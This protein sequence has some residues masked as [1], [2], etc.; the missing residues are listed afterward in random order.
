[1]KMMNRETHIFEMK[2]CNDM[3]CVKS[4]MQYLNKLIS[5]IPYYKLLCLKKSAVHN[6]AICRFFC[7]KF[8]SACNSKGI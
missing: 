8:F 1:M 6:Y 2:M 4:T 3:Y 5:E 7:R